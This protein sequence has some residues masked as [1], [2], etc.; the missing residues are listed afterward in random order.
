MSE[1][2]VLE[3]GEPAPESEEAAAAEAPA[4]APEDAP[5]AEDAPQ[6]ESELDRL[7]AELEQASADQ[8]ELLD[9]LQRAQAEFENIRKRLQREKE[10]VVRYAASETIESLLPIVDDFERAIKA[11]G[12]TA[13]IKKG[14]ELIHRRIFEVFSRAGL[15]EVPQHETFDPNLHFAV[16]RAAATDDQADQQILDVY[17]KGYFFKDRLVRASMVKVAVKD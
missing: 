6:P 14:L 10:E 3:V 13:D 9:K 15:K 12:V 7:R 8:A 1:T 5:A 11:E 16:D 17:Q 4:G 2:E